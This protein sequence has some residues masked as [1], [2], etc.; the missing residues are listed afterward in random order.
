MILWEEN[1]MEFKD[2]RKVMQSHFKEMVDDVDYLFE[3]DVDKDE[4]WNT[5]LDSY[6]A[7]TNLI[8]RKRREFDCSCCRQ[9]IKTVGNAVSI[10]NGKIDTVWNLNVGDDKFQVVADAMDAF[11]R[12]KSVIN[13]FVSNF[14]KIGT[15]YN[16]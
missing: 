5:Y 9:F 8:Y 10:K 15:E 6:P 3:V 13:I 14:K 16:M 12:S 11:I 1:N 7:G 4:M 2:F